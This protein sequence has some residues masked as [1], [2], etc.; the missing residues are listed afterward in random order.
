MDYIN[1]C[2][3]AK[4]MMA[5]PVN[6]KIIKLGQNINSDYDDASPALT[7][8]GKTLV[9]TSRRVADGIEKLN[10]DVN[11]YN[12]KM[13]I[14]KWDATKNTWD[15]AQP[16]GEEINYQGHIGSLSLSHD[17]KTMFIFKNIPEETNSG[18][19]FISELLT[20]GKWTKPVGIG[21]PVNSSY[22]ESSACLSPDGQVLY[23]VSERKGGF[24]SADIFRSHRLTANKWSTPENLK[25]VI[26]SEYDELGVY[27]HSDGKTLYFSSNG[28]DNMGGY[29]IF[30]ST[31]EEGVWSQPKNLG[32]P[33]NSTF[34]EKH[35]ILSADGKTA[36]MSS[37]RDGVYDI[38]QV[39]MSNYASKEPVKVVTQ[40]VT[41]A[42]QIPSAAVNAGEKP[43]KKKAE[44]EI[45]VY[46]DYND[47]KVA[48][49]NPSNTGDFI[50]KLKANETYSISIINKD[51]QKI[52]ASVKT[53]ES[54]EYNLKIS[55]SEEI[56]VS[57]EKNWKNAILRI[58]MINK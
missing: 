35:F 3:R 15:V 42:G 7:P 1:S 30:M 39:D 56:L 48:T 32:Y 46:N 27:I 12:D 19:I 45:S 9:F 57:I 14:S 52:V 8:D 36:Y 10:T 13:Y 18:D 24:G 21:K 28:H 31:L 17:G 50:L 37:N 26:N 6:A 47:E 22:F 41:E 23:F 2:L 34:D 5:S 58:K 11:P 25:G 38:Y 33:I 44:T 20:D 49:F 40:Y 54:G 29:D 53:N 51:E 55:Q 4:E 43:A 16:A